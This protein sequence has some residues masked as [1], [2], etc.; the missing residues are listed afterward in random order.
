MITF[1]KLELA[2]EKKRFRGNFNVGHETFIAT[3]L[4]FRFHN[5]LQDPGHT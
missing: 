2:A 4:E 3:F 5:S 1:S